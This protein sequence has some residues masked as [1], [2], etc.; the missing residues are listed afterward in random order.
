MAYLLSDYP[1]PAR[2]AASRTKAKRLDVRACRRLCALAAAA[3]LGEMG[4][5]ERGLYDSLAASELVPGSG[6]LI[7]TLQAQVSADS[8]GFL[9]YGRILSRQPDS[10]EVLDLT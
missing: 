2:L 1:V 7:A 6:R 8:V 4:P 5:E 10:F 3:D 9:G